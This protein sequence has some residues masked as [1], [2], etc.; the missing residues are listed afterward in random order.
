M[1]SALESLG[2][3]PLTFVERADH[4]PFDA[5]ELARLDVLGKR[6]G[7]DAWVVDAKTHAHLPGELRATAIVL[8]QSVEPSPELM[9]RILSHAKLANASTRC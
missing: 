4:R 6:C 1:R 3:H 7:V 5:R 8:S 9:R 2:V